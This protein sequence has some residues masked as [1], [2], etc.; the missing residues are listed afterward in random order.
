MASLQ[1]STPPAPPKT[2]AELAS[3]HGI[4]LEA[5]L[6]LQRT[7]L[8]NHR[9]QVESELRDKMRREVRKDVTEEVR[10][11]LRKEAESAQMSAK[12]RQ[13]F[14]AY[15]R[16]AEL[17]ALAGAVTLEKKQGR[18]KERFA[19]TMKVRNTTMFG[20]VCTPLL[21]ALTYATLG[22]SPV[23]IALICTFALIMV[24]L[25][26]R[27][28]EKSKEDG[29]TIAGIGRNVGDCYWL[30][31]SAKNHRKL[32]LATAKTEGELLNGI[33]NFKE[34]KRDLDHKVRPRMEDLAAARAIVRDM[35]LSDMDPETLFRVSEPTPVESEALGEGEESQAKRK[36]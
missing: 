2:E 21:G 22:L 26:A 12:T 8:A 4:T 10:Y 20:L 16:E 1:P 36:V 17:D 29:V 14:E 23:G 18:V 11:Q 7:I 15:F 9:Y 24:V 35:L 5:F 30:A 19:R 13:S 33:G 3:E 34:Q 32:T 25:T 6:A 27:F 28:D 31:T